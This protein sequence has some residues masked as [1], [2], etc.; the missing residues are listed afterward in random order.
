MPSFCVIERFREGNLLENSRQIVGIFLLATVP[1]IC[2]IHK[3]Q[4]GPRMTT[5][6]L[7][8]IYY[9]QS[10]WRPC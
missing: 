10:N 4:S 1:P 6:L 8:P 2:L 7:S 9:A 5:S 3:G